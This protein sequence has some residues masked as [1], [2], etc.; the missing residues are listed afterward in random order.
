MKITKA[1]LLGGC[2][3]ALAGTAHAAD[4]HTKAPAAVYAP[5]P[6]SYNWTGFYVGA[7]LGGAAGDAVVTDTNGG[8]PPGP[9]GYK[10][11][12]V[13]GGGQVGYNQQFLDRFVFGVEADLGYLGASGKG[14]IGSANAAAHQDLTMKGGFYADVTGRLGIAMLDNRLLAYGKG[15]YVYFDTDARQQTTNPGYVTTGTGAYSG[16]AFG[17]G[18]EYAL[19]QNVSIKA[20]YLRF[21]LGSRG[22]YQTSISDPPIGYQYR[23]D[24]SLKINTLTVGVNYHF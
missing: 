20:E 12:G 18:L 8:V 19:W 4:L 10:T 21:D 7:H 3:A 14:T 15:G 13:F 9:F 23:N 5:V 24:T 16:T 22:G 17:G 1:L 2:F 6:V 11:S